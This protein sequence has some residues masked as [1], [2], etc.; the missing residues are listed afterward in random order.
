[1]LIGYPVWLIRLT[2]WWLRTRLQRLRTPPA[3]VSFLIEAPPP[4]PVAP[5]QPFWQRFLGRPPLTVDALSAQLR[6]AS[7][8]PHVKGAVLHLRPLPLNGAQVDALR[9]LIAEVRGAGR[10]VVCWAPSFTAATYVVACAADEILLQPG[11]MVGPLG[12]ARDYVFLA[13]ALE[14]LGIRADLLKISPYKT[15]GDVVARKD[16]TPEA[17]EM[18]EWLADGAF[19]ETVLAIGSGRG[20]GETRARELIDASPLTDEQALSL[21]AVDALL[22]EEE[23][24]TRLEGG[25]LSWPVARRRLPSPPPPKPARVVGLLRIEGLIVDGRSRRAPVRPPLAPPVVF[26]DQCGDL[27]VVEQART[28]AADRRVGAVVVWVD[29]GGGSATASE[30]MASALAVL[31]RS[32]PVVAGMGAVAA[33]GGYYVTTAARKLFA[34]PR[35]TTGS[36]GVLAGKVVVGGFFDRLLVHRDQVV[37][38]QHADMF[39]PERPFTET[40]RTKM[41]QMIERSYQL[42]LSRVGAARGRTPEELEPL[43]GGR[44]WTGRQAHERGLVDELGGLQMAIAEARR[45]GGLAPDAPV[46]EPRQGRRELPNVPATVPATLEHVLRAIA[47]LQQAGAWWLCPLVSPNES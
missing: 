6:Q 26:Q 25:L 11:G 45:L 5:R 27:T 3:Y 36:I 44:V 24:A 9:D 41:I 14:W 42:F 33:S 46:R 18:A 19:T 1:M 40:E 4:E 2:V 22:G 29:S 10:R 16:F 34:H 28:L 13:E 37:R 31:A 32:K 35:T 12:L 47:C 15:A 39:S 8:D 7:A 30:A 43:A 17:R 23:L 20:V 21:G 38:G